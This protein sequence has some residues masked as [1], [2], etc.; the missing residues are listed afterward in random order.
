MEIELPFFYKYDFSDNFSETVRYGKI[1]E[2]LSTSI[3][4]I[5][6]DDVVNE[7]KIEKYKHESIRNSAISLY[8][9]EKYKSNKD[10]FEAVKQ[11]CLSFL[12]EF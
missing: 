6:I 4:E 7:Y 12:S 9:E 5:K 1:E 2:N 3:E 10:E 11:R 8:S